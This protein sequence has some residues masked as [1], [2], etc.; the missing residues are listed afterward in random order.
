MSSKCIDFLYVIKSII[1]NDCFVICV[2][3]SLL[4]KTVDMT[5]LFRW[6]VANAFMVATFAFSTRVSSHFSHFASSS[7]FF[8][9]ALA[10]LILFLSSFASS[11]LHL[12]SSFSHIKFWNSFEDIHLGIFDMRT[13]S[14]F[15]FLMTGVIKTSLRISEH[16]AEE[17][18]AVGDVVSTHA[19]F[20]SSSG[21]IE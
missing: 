21:V 1:V 10:C 13:P 9:S 11:S 19:S 14:I 6:G 5:F 15:F 3:L 20:G 8:S 17:T 4:S 2:G 18:G 7:H 12:A 16:F